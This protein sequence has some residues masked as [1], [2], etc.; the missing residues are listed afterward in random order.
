M[1]T[2]CRQLE[3]SMSPSVL[4]HR[5]DFEEETNERSGSDE[6]KS[7][8]DEEK[9]D[10]ENG[11]SPSNGELEMRYLPFPDNWIKGQKK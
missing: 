8:T 6:S 3:T 2:S 7:E 9:S 10:L 1:R 5:D 4:H 11:A